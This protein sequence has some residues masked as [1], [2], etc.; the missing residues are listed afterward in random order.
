MACAALATIGISTLPLGS[1][2]F[3]TAND[4]IKRNS[5]LDDINHQRSYGRQI[6]SP[7]SAE[8]AS[9]SPRSLPL[10]SQDGKYVRKVPR[11]DDDGDPYA[12]M[13][14]LPGELPL[15]VVDIATSAIGD[16]SEAAAR[17]GGKRKLDMIHVNILFGKRLSFF[18]M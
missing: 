9:F 15:N 13:T 12:E 2:K 14:R 17:D 18:G 6:V 4:L 10:P 16:L 5:A 1:R 3:V 11:D 7:R 8:T